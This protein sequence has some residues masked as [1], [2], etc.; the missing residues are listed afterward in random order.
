M[1]ILLL[2][3]FVMYIPVNFDDE[4]VDM[5]IEVGDKEIDAIVGMEKN[6]VLTEKTETRKPPQTQKIPHRLFSVR[7]VIAHHSRA[8]LDDVFVLTVWNLHSLSET[9]NL[10]TCPPSLKKGRRNV[11][12]KFYF[13]FILS[14][15][16]FLREGGWGIG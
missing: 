2:F 6:G 1:I 3:F 4:S 15:L 10:S 7:G 13:N 14:P 5:T 9:D 12:P 11:L 8:F 16:P